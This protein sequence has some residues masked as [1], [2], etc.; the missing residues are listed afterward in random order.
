MS[1]ISKPISLP[2]PPGPRSFS[3]LGHA[4]A[5]QRDAM[6]FTQ[7]MWLRYGDVV[8][9]RL[10][11]QPATILFH[12]DHVQRVL[13]ENH[14]NYDKQ[15]LIYQAVSGLLGN[16][17]FTNTGDS[18]RTNRR[19]IQSLFH[20]HL[21]GRFAGIM[22]SSALVMAERWKEAADR[23][24]VLDIPGEMTRLTLQITAQAL[25][26]TETPEVSLSVQKSFE[27]VWNAFSHYV[28]LPVPPL[29]IPTPRNL[30]ICQSARQ[31]DQIIYM[32]F[33]KLI[34]YTQANVA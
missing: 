14:F 20:K 18:W 31:L 12:P 30:R 4:I 26:S 7:T 1:Q 25:F 27:Q 28:A 34:W 8:R 19:L 17:L 5:I 24:H 3:P 10:L 32:L 15:G 6:H 2:I 16:G 29:C 13:Q 11:M 23:K 21:L 33:Y 9:F 22:S